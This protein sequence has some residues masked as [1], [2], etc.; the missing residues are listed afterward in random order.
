M[1][2]LAFRHADME[3]SA[4]IKECFRQARDLS[5]HAANVVSKYAQVAGQV[6]QM[7]LPD[8]RLAVSEKE[9]QLAVNLLAMVKEWVATMR[10]DG[11]EIQRRYMALQDSV[12]TLI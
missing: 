11:E 8:L 9:P 6:S 5:T 3:L 10:D 4:A 12:N 1:A 2:C 7:V